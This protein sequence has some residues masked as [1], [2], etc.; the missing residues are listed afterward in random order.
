M[1]WGNS[2]SFLFLIFSYYLHSEKRQLPCTCST[3]SIPQSTSPTNAAYYWFSL[4]PTECEL[5]DQGTICSTLSYL[6]RN[7][8]LL[9]LKAG[10][11]FF[12]ME[13]N[14]AHSLKT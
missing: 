14:S 1:S 4:P 10:C 3:S 7:V 11:S 2:I 8:P 9:V 12:L 13:S 6:L 5:E